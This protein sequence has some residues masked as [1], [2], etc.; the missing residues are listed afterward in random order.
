MKLGDL[1]FPIDDWDQLPYRALLDLK[2]FLEKGL[3]SP[4]WSA[5]GEIILGNAK[6]FENAILFPSE[7]PS[8]DGAFSTERNRGKLQ[9]T[10]ILLNAPATLLEQVQAQIEVLQAQEPQNEQDAL[11]AFDGDGVLRRE[12]DEPLDPSAS[13]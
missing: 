10:A 2:A 13:P 3:A 11:K 5:Y 8:L 9:A 7:Q 12:R 6:G 4:F 1:E